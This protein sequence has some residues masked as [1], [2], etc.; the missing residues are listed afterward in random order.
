MALGKPILTNTSDGQTISVVGDLYRFLVTGEQTGGKYATWEARI[1]PGGGPP[2]HRHQREDESFY[3][4]EGEVVFT[5][6]GQRMVA[7]AGQFVHLPVGSLHHF[8]NETEQPA[9]ML[10]T[11]FP[12]GFEQMLLTV[13]TPVDPSMTVAPPP[14]ASEISR[15][16]ELAP[17]YGVEINPSAETP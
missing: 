17:Q 9:R 4:L 16:L 8:K 6:D 5:A 15:L 12:A 3:V 7:T 10:I 13:G 14:T 2:P 1:S 11:V